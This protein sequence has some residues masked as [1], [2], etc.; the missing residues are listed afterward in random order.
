MGKEQL[1]KRLSYEESVKKQLKCDRLEREYKQMVDARYALVN[2]KGYYGTNLSTG[3]VYDT[4]IME[5]NIR[6]HADEI[7]SLKK[8][9][10]E[11]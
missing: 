5:R 3:V 1:K 2:V 7:I 6:M 10:D 9:L 4:R 11:G 8:E